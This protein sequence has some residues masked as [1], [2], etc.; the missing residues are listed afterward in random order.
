MRELGFR[1][2]SGII[3]SDN[4]NPFGNGLYAVR[5]TPELFAFSANEFEVYHMSVTGPGGSALQVWVN[6]TFY[7]TTP[8]GDINSWD[9]SNALHMYGGQTLNFYWSLGT[10]TVPFVTV[11]CR[12]LSVL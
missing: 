10:G 12:E 2:A 3:I 9:P 11:W 6:T 1:Q 4:T 7:D 5:F 8:R